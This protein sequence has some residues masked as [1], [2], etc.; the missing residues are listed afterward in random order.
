MEAEFSN[1]PPR[2]SEE[3][4]ELGHSVKKFKE[5]NGVRQFVHP[6]IPVNYKNSLVGDIPG[7]YEQAFTYDKVWDDDED[8]NTDI[9]P[10]LEGMAEVK[11]SKATKACIRT[12]WSK[13]LIVKVF[14]RIVGF[15]NLN[16]KINA[17]WNPAAKMDCVNLGKDYFLIKFSSS[18][19]GPGLLG[20]TSR[21][22]SHGSPISRHLRQ[23]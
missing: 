10:L 7:A 18:E 11:L 13:A 12:P 22:S 21:L 19:E 20:N 4:D 2:S 15:K 14:G 17:I 6:R 9:K 23:N 3:E 16:S 1:E 8:F 5:S